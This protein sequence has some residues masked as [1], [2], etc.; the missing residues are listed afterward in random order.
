MKVLLVISALGKDRPGLLK[1]LAQALMECGCT[2]A[3]SRMTV[4][5][6]EFAAVLMITGNWSAI[7]KVEGGLSALQE[8]LGLTISARRTEVRSTET[9]LLPYIAEIVTVD[10]PGIIYRM[11]DFFTARSINIEDLYTSGYTSAHSATP[12]FA[13]N[14][15][16]N[17][18]ASVHIAALRDEFMNLCEEMNLD[19][20][21]EP[22]KR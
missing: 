13:L 4:L 18:P 11:A 2:I 1:E 14:L 22:L 7:A 19:G 17:I 3:D 8:R 20:V 21:L 10:R 12:M 5:G 16:V 15:T 9:P 6:S